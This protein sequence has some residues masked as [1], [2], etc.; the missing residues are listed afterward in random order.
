MRTR[1]KQWP[2]HL[3]WAEFWFH[4]NFNIS[5][6]ISLFKALYGHNPP[7]LVKGAK[8]SSKL[9]EVNKLNR[10]RYELLQ[11]LRNN[12]LKAQGQMK[13][14]A[15]YHKRELEFH[16]G[17]WVFMKLQPCRMRSLARRTNEKLSLR[18][19]ELYKVLQRIREVTYKLDLP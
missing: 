3:A 1:P 10:D 5:A 9:E 2:N 16:M 6:K 14:Y 15:N 11:D 19:Y 8:V 13:K 18:F 17:D 7:L 4:A 12:L